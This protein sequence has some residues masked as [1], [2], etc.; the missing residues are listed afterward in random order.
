[1]N[2]KKSLKKNICLLL[3]LCYCLVCTGCGSGGTGYG[4]KAVMTLVDQEYSIA[5]RN[6]D[7]TAY[8]VI[9]AI[10][11]LDEE[12]MDDLPADQAPLERTDNVMV[13]QVVQEAILM[14][15]IDKAQYV[16]FVQQIA[17]EASYTMVYTNQA[18]AVRALTHLLDNALKFTTEGTITLKVAVD[19]DKMQV[20]Y[21]VEDTGSGIEAGAEERI[22][23]PY[24]KLNQYFDGQGI[25]LTVAR[26]IA[27]RLEGDLVLDTTYEGP[28][29]RFVLTLPI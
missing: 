22:F 26:N 1:M 6:D 11:A 10:Q 23:E 19:M 5:F 18:K 29:A 4:V 12:G 15:G 13:T 3:A 25:G 28:G 9:G 7:P 16:Q 21:T 14:S 17:D 27:R 8:Y 24:V 2:H 20:A